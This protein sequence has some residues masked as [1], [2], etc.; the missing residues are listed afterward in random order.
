M[1]DFMT[2]LNHHAPLAIAALA[3]IFL[4]FIVEALRLKAKHYCI[5]TATAV[6]LIN[7]EN[8]VVIDIRT[9][10]TYQA[11]H[12][13]DAQTISASDLKTPFKKLD[14]YKNKPL[15]VVCDAGVSSQKVAAELLAA[16]FK[17]HSLTGGMRAWLDAGIPTV[18]G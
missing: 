6:Q 9:P 2:F 14:K 15:I 16:G 5:D 18:K 1:Q 10:E 12:I 17:A 3:V 8:A 4:L 7:R 13:T 11:G